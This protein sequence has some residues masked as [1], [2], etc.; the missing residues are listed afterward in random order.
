M[1]IVVNAASQGDLTQQIMVTGDD[2]IGQMGT[3]LQR[4]LTDLSTN[5]AVIAHNAQA[6][7][8]SSEELTA[9]SQQMGE[10]SERTATQ[11]NGAS[12]ASEL[13]SQNVST[14][15]TFGRMGHGLRPW[16]AKRGSQLRDALSRIT[17]TSACVCVSTPALLRR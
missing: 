11:A 13:V 15:A 5:I 1:L 9:V 2:A 8:S 17:K 10:N 14:V 4:L 7:A 12:S 6:L 16:R 3:A